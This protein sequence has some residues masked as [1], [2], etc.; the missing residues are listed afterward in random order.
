MNTSGFRISESWQIAVEVAKLAYKMS[1]EIKLEK[2]NLVALK[3]LGN[4]QDACLEIAPSIAEALS[5]ADASNTLALMSKAKGYTSRAECI[6]V[7]GVN[8][9]FFDLKTPT[10]AGLVD[11][12]QE[13]QV[14]LDKELMPLGNRN[15]AG[16]FQLKRP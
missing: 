15:G 11:K 8:M 12:L 3:L 6:L 2:D 16:G 1:E 7:M 5:Q 10:A 14:A 9:T 13:Q 4:L